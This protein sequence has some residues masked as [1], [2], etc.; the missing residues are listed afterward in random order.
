MLQLFAEGKSMKEIA[1]AVN[2]STRTV[3]WH[4]HRLMKV[5]SL[6][7]SAELVQFAVRMKLVT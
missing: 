2:L 3:E 1:T 7:R 6:R 5:L 4:K